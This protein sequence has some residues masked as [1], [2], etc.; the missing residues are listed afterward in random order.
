MPGAR[1]KNKTLVDIL[2]QSRDLYGRKTCM[3]SFKEDRFVDISYAEFAETVFNIA[4][5]LLSIGL[6]PEDT[7]C[8]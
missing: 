2:R 3:K 8:P 1:F 5:G 7:W 6:K 4:R